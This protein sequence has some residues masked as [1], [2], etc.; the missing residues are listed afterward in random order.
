MYE[1][2]NQ[3]LIE[4]QARLKADFESVLKTQGLQPAQPAEPHPEPRADS[5][6]TTQRADQPESENRYLAAESEAQAARA[7][8][9]DL[10]RQLD[11]SERA[12]S[13]MAAILSGMGI[14]VR[15]PGR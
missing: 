8:V 10:R 9:E 15:M 11:E 13:E 2:R 1:E 14:R 12:K 5:R 4:A 7:E 6:E 3:E